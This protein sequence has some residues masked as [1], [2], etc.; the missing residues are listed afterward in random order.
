VPQ[1]T[2]TACAESAARSKPEFTQSRKQHRSKTTKKERLCQKPAH[3]SAT[4]AG[5]FPSRTGP[6]T[7]PR[8][9]STHVIV[10]ALVETLGFRQ[11]RVMADEYA[12]SPNGMKMFGVLDLET[13]CMAAASQSA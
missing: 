7:N 8:R 1:E 4:R 6:H 13:E 5:R 10:Q 12:V 2:L 9:T 3:L 11:I